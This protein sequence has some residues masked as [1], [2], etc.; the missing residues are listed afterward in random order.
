DGFVFICK[1][2]YSSF[3]GFFQTRRLLRCARSLA[4]ARSLLTANFVFQNWT[5]L[6]LFV[7]NFIPPS[8]VFFKQDVCFV[9]LVLSLS[10]APYS[11]PI[12]F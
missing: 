5:A 10:L 7:K 2:L 8:E 1:K 3:G 12:L 11:L 4:V 6:S 9:A